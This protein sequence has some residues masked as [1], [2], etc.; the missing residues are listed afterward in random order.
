MSGILRA[1]LSKWGVGIFPEAF[2]N[3]AQE[4]PGRHAPVSSRPGVLLLGS[5]GTRLGWDLESGYLCLRLSHHLPQSK[6]LFLLEGT[7]LLGVGLVH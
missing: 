1:G 6:G 2:R 4:T 5:S 7:A 3:H